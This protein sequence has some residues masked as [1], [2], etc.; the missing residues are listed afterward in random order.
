MSIGLHD[1]PNFR[2]FCEAACVKL[3][4]EPDSRNARELRW[5]G[6]DAY[7]AKTFNRQKKAWYDHGEQRGGSTLDLVAYDKG[8]PKHD[9][10]GSAFFDA[11]SAA[12]AMGLVPDEPPAKANGQGGSILATYPYHDEAGQPLFE[13]VRFDATDS[14]NRFRQRRPDGAGGWIW[15]TKGVRSHIL[16]RLPTLIEALKAGQRVLITEGEHDC[17]TAVALG[18]VATTMPGGVGKWRSE[19][20]HFFQDADV[21]IVSDNDPQ[22]RDK[23]TRALQFHPDGKPKLPGQDHA[24]TV[25]R[26]MRK[27]AARVRVVIFPQKDLTAWREAGGTTAT[28]EALIDSTP[29]Y[30]GSEPPQPSAPEPEPTPPAPEKHGL[31]NYSDEAL[32]LTFAD[33]HHADLRFVPL[34]SKWL[35]WDG[36]RWKLDDRTV[37]FTRARIICREV[38]ATYKGKRACDI[39][40]SKKVAAIGTLARGD[41]RHVAT[42]DQWDARLT[43]LSMPRLWCMDTLTPSRDVIVLEAR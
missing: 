35:L 31:P 22:S 17:N 34:W 23:K 7:S 38:A 16:Y 30:E 15:D 25:A 29:D 33:R 27:V 28:L 32:A 10:K 41:S 42:A 24:A 1:L 26:H 5:N 3:W 21:V 39:A 9:L 6:A 40:S 4:G 13:V 12:H 19:Y 43:R 8:Q 14:D 37:A 36:S 11:W 20:D 2:D 18:F